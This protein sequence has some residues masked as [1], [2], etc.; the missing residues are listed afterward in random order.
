MRRFYTWTRLTGSSFRAGAHAVP[1]IL[2]RPVERLIRA[3]HQRASVG[4]VLWKRDD[5]QADGDLS[6]RLRVL[7]WE[8]MV[9]DPPAKL[10]GHD[11]RSIFGRFGKEHHEFL[12]AITRHHRT[13]AQ[14]LRED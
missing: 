9:L 2:L 4:A 8:G 10:L 3:L 12:S 13:T 1:A 5:P 14:A 7:P 11:Q 6:V